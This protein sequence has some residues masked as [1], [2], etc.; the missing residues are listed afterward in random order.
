MGGPPVWVQRHL[1][2]DGA[3]LQTGFQLVRFAEAEPYQPQTPRWLPITV[4]QL[5]EL[6]GAR[7]DQ[8]RG[9]GYVPRPD[10][11]EPQ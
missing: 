8:D 1:A 10:E 2:S 6:V 11:P 5:E 7:V 3:A 9:T 4:G